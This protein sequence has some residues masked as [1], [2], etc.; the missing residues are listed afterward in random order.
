MKILLVDDHP[1]FRK[2]MVET[3]VGMPFGVETL[4]ARSAQEALVL[5]GDHADIDYLFLDLQLPDMDGLTF[6]GELEARALAVPVVVLSADD[7]VRRVDRCLRAGAQGYLSKS[8]LAD[9]IAEALTAMETVGY[10]VERALRGPLRDY[11]RGMT[12]DQWLGTRLTRRQQQVLECLAEGMSNRDIA[13]ALDIS[14]STVKGHVATLFALLDA[15]SRTQ[16]I[17][18][19]RKKGLTL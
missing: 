10:Y 1:L 16:C 5:L 11:R 2:G 3:M 19:A 4:E 15:G 14:V 7:G 12:V 18:L 6:L 17:S 8:A 9:E 13:Q